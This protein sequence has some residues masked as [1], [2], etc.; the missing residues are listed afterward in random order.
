MALISREKWAATSM[1]P[2]ATERAAK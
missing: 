1:E 2:P